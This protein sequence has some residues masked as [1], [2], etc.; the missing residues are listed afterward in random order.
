MP[1]TELQKREMLNCV[2]LVS[3]KRWMKSRLWLVS[4]SGH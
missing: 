3:H 1:Y 4:Q 2:N